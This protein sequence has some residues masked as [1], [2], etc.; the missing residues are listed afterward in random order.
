MTQKVH[1]G[2]PDR[3]GSGKMGKRIVPVQSLSIKAYLGPVGSNIEALCDLT[4]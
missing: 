2:E 4:K 3:K 1:K